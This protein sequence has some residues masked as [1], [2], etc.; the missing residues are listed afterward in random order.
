LPLLFILGPWRR[1]SGD[2]W[3]ASFRNKGR[4]APESAPNRTVSQA[5]NQET[6]EPE[7]I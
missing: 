2:G 1:S 3:S 5:S 7:R 4:L 6:D